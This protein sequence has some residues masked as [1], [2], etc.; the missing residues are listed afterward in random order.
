MMATRSALLADQRG[1]AHGF[2]GR[3]GGVSTGLYE[4]LNCGLGSGDNRTDVWENRTRV[5]AQLS[6]APD[7]LLTA[8]QIHSPIVRIVDAGWDAADAPQADGM[9]TTQPGMAL[10]VLAADCTPILFADDHAKVIG[11]CHAG[12]KG[13][14]AG[15]ADATVAAM[16]A[17]GAKPERI[18]AAIGPTIRQPAYEVGAE[19]RDRFTAA[20]PA[21]AGWFAPGAFHGKFQFDLPGYL[22]ARLRAIGVRQIEDLNICTY[23][24][25]YFSYRRATHRGEPH[26]GRNIS[27]IALT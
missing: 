7:R 3:T 18:V 26:Y 25:D 11:A 24:G 22:A 6:V 20:D 23:D 14:L 1:V 10:G 13:A 5:A 2:F 12:W 17:L 4:S 15:I 16:A 9:V 19:F 8:H 21:N 27:T